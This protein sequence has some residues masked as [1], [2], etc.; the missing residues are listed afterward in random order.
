MQIRKLRF[1][2]SGGFAGVVRG[3]EA[4]GA[5][6]SPAERTA[7]AR[8]LTSPSVARA[9]GARDLLIYEWEVDTDEGPRR[10][11]VDE[12][13]VPDGLASLVSKLARQSR[14]VAL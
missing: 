4:D 13:N 10:V 2:V 12:M 8:L 1:R 3:T 5:A 9:P 14:P 11:E 6:L 7:L